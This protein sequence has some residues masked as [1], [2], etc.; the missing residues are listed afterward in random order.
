VLSAFVRFRRLEESRIDL[1]HASLAALPQKSA[2][3]DRGF[4]A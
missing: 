1:Q 2:F 3:I 4:A